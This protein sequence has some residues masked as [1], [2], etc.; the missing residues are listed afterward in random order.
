MLLEQAA[1]G[2]DRISPNSRAVRRSMNRMDKG[3]KKLIMT[4]NAVA[5]DVYDDY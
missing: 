2:P 1:G 4:A 3:I 5:T